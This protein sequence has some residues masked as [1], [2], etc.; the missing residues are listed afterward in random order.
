VHGDVE[1]RALLEVVEGG[2][3]VGDGLVAAVE[4]RPEDRD[5]ADGVLVAR[6][7]GRRSLKLK[8]P[9][10]AAPLRP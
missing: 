1:A 6:C 4:R 10:C 2:A 5:D 9:G 7:G 3:D 8:R